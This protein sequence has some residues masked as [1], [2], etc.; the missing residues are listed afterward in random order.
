MIENNLDKEALKVVLNEQFT[1]FE[2]KDL[3]VERDQ[4]QTVRKHLKTPF[5]IV[6]S[7]LRRVGKST[8]LAQV[9]RKFYPRGFYYVNF[10]D[11]RLLN[12]TVSDFDLL[13]ETLVELFGEKKVFI[14]DEIQNVSGWERFVRRMIDQGFKFYLAGSNAALLSRELGTKLTGRYLSLELLPFSFGEFIRFKDLKMP[15]NLSLLETAARG[16]LKKAFNEYL[17]YGGIPDILKYPEAGWSKTLYEDVLF[18]DVASRYK[19]SE[20][21][22]LKELAFFLISNVGRLV[23]YNKLK[24]QLKLG[25][26][27]TVKS[28]IDYMEAGWLFF[29]VSQYAW[30]VKKQQIAAKKIYGI[31][32]GLIQEVSFAFSKNRGNLLENL[33]LLELK[34]RQKE[35]FYYKTI[36]GLEVDFYLP[37]DK[38]LIQVTQIL[39]DVNRDREINA[40]KQAM[41]ETGGNFSLILTE[42]KHEEIKFNK[43]SIKVQ[44]LYEWL[45]EKAPTVW[46]GSRIRR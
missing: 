8:L 1:G 17:R 45:M 41:T 25:S 4:I 23:S 11:E 10:E 36:D 43:I 30:S 40:L 3:G 32:T 28:Y 24:D 21:K 12:F 27:N 22:A 6:F 35:V 42:D 29:V 39:R 20:V 46:G 15:A 14:L 44:P 16:N 5:A 9:A 13:Y 38:F 19:I 18:R 26:V 37:K 2:K 31:D 34:R 33:V 7:G